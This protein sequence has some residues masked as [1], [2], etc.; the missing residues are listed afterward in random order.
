MAKSTKRLVLSYEEF[1]HREK[2]EKYRGGLGPP[3]HNNF[4]LH[5]LEDP[6]YGFRDSDSLIGLRDENPELERRLT[7]EI[8]KAIEEDKN[9]NFIFELEPDLYQA[10][11]IMHKY[12][13][14][15]EEL[16]R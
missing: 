8:T 3:H 9:T 11:Q 4:F 14:D 10:Y 1:T 12:V 13:Q 2:G 6:M 15:D 5:F 7:E 16:F